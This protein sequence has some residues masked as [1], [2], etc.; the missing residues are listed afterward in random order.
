[1]YKFMS[2]VKFNNQYFEHGDEVVVT[3]KDNSAIVGSIVIEDADNNKTT[4]WTLYLDTSEK[5][6]KNIISIKRC[7]IESIQKVNER[8]LN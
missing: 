2:V 6:H 5:Y 4:Y 8:K 7:D 1:M 3:K